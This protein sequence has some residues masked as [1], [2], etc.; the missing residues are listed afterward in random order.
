MDALCLQGSLLC[1]CNGGR[2][3]FL[4][5][6]AAVAS[7]LLN[8]MGFA[9][10]R[11][12]TF[13][14]AVIAFAALF[15]AACGGD[16]SSAGSTTSAASTKPAASN[17]TSGPSSNSSQSSSGEKNSEGQ[18]VS[19]QLQLS[20]KWTGTFGWNKDLAVTYCS[21]IRV[22]F[23]MTDGKGNFISISS[24]KLNDGTDKSVLGSGT[25]PGRGY[26]GKSAQLDAKLTPNKLGA[27]GTVSWENVD[28]KSP[29][30]DSVKVAGK[31][32][33]NCPG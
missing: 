14:L 32:T 17:A 18:S 26:L 11:S 10:F 29:D 23:T 27:S 15:L 5:A 25:L 28:F 21:D 7:P 24:A 8:E 9:V 1:H 19:G 12:F 16:D 20:G 2:R 3:H 4:I 6:V 30:G 31:L 13:A 22:D 33:F